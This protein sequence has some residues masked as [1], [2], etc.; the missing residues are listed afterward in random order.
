MFLSSTWPVCEKQTK[1]LGQS[2]S[3]VTHHSAVRMRNVLSCP[4][5]LNASD[6]LRCSEDEKHV[7]LSFTYECQ[8]LTEVQWGWASDSMRYSADEKHVAL[9]FTL[10]CQWLIKVQWGWDTCPVFTHQWTISFFSLWNVIVFWR[11]FDPFYI[12]KIHFILGI[13]VYTVATAINNTSA[14][15]EHL[16]MNRP[17][18]KFPFYRFIC[19]SWH[20]NVPIRVE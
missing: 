12:Y 14:K 17:A 15:L 5:L 10:E 8:W 11:F 16:R 6:S 13:T 19:Y 20:E 1:I 2:L 18:A 4:L 9:S 7:A 3:A